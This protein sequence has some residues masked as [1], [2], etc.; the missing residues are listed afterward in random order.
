M[1]KEERQKLWETR[2]AEFKA[3]GQGVTAWCSEHDV[4]P[5]LLWYWLKKER[6]QESKEK[7]VAWLPVN[8]SDTNHHPSFL[9]R[10]GQVSVEVGP[11][12]DPKLLLDV[13]RTLMTQ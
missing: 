4:N 3:S 1:T 7:E 6:Q 13:V 11:G 10:A 12:F 9:V 5:Q 8:L 2:I